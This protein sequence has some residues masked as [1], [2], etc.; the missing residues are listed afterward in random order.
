M[1]GISAKD[2]TLF[3]EEGKKI[4]QAGLVTWLAESML[5]PNAALQDFV[6]WEAIDDTQAKASISWE[7]IS[8]EGIF[9]FKENGELESFCT[10][11][12]V[13]TDA[14]GNERSVEWTAEFSEYHPVNGILQ[15]EVI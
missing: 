11:D 9:T 4:D 1:K 7:G 15:P 12:K 3:G 14:T 2:I 8:A 6:T 13:A 10:K 5:F